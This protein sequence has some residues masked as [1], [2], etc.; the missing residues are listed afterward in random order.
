MPWVERFGGLQSM[1][2]QRVRHD[3]ATECTHTHIHTHSHTQTHT[4]THT[5][6]HTP[7]GIDLEIY[8]FLHSKI[9]RG[10]R[11]ENQKNKVGKTNIL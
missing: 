1:G 8:A 4:L 2:S 7:Q 6:T 9:Q 3:W 11:E 5:H 10:W